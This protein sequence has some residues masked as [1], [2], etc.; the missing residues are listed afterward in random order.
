[1]LFLRW[2][3]YFRGPGLDHGSELLFLGGCF[4]QCQGKRRSALGP[5]AGENLSISTEFSAIASTDYTDRDLD[6]SFGRRDLTHRNTHGPLIG[7]VDGTVLL[8]LIVGE[9]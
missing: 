9:G 3:C 6:Q 8:P 5:V 1:M 2:S 4:F 7:A